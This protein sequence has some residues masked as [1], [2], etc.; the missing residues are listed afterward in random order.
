MSE[1]IELKQ[2]PN[3]P[4]IICRHGNWFLRSPDD[5]GLTHYPLIVG[6]VAMR[7]WLQE[8]ER[9]EVPVQANSLHQD[10]QWM[11]AKDARRQ[12]EL[13]SKYAGGEK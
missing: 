12:A 8:A 7:A 3:C 13:W 9:L 6:S 11:D 1:P 5:I 2:P 10:E 4:Q